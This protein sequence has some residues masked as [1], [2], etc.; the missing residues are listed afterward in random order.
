MI[1][2]MKTRC[3][4]CTV[5]LVWSKSCSFFV[6]DVVWTSWVVLP[7][8]LFLFMRVHMLIFRLQSFCCIDKKG[9]LSWPNPTAEKVFILTKA[10]QSTLAMS[11]RTSRTR[12]Y[13]SHASAAG[14]HPESCALSHSLS[15]ERCAQPGAYDSTYII[16]W[17]HW[18]WFTFQCL[19]V[20]VSSFTFSQICRSLSADLEYCANYN[21]G[22]LTCCTGLQ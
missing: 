16:A 7:Q 18:S 4:N 19:A 9:V 5:R 1:V 22:L 8:F 12:R 14:D 20:A 6:H 10:H 3:C 15:H 17:C 11:D 13:S 2:P 21:R